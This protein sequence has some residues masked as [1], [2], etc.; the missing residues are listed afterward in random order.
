M[1]A[2]TFPK[3]LFDAALSTHPNQIRSGSYRESHVLKQNVINT[4]SIPK[5]PY[6]LDFQEDNITAYWGCLCRANEGPN[7]T[8]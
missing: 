4:T 7:S 5:K 8:S 6:A 3:H 2:T 1:H